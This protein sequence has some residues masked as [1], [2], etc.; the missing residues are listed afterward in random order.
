MQLVSLY[1]RSGVDIIREIKFRD[2]INIIT[3]S[4]DDG[5][6]IGKSTTLRAIKFCL[7]SDGTNLWHDPDSGVTNHEIFDL[8]VSGIVSF[9]LNLN[10]NGKPIKIV[11][12]MH[13]KTS[14]I[15]RVSWINGTKYSFHKK[16]KDEISNI[17]GHSPSK[18]SFS[19]IQNRFF[20]LD[21]KSV[22]ALYRYNNAFTSNDDYRLI[23]SHLFG[24]SGHAELEKDLDFKAE[25]SS[26]E[27]R[28]SSLLNGHTE[29]EYQDKLSSIGD[30][31][32]TLTE[33][34]EL[35]DI[36]GV[37]NN[38]IKNVRSCREEIAYISS[39]ITDLETR[40]LYNEKTIFD[41]EAKITRIDS[42]V[43]ASIYTEAKTIIPDLST[44]F[45]DAINFHNSMF[46][47]KAVYVASQV[48]VLRGNL[49]RHKIRLN[50]VLDTEKNLFK[51]IVNESHL[52]GFILIEREIQDKREERGKI[53]YVV[54][55][56]NSI[57]LDISALSD[58][59]L[60]MQAL[61]RRYVSDFRDN[62]LA[63]NTSCK[64]ITKKVFNDFSIYFNTPEDQDNSVNFT[65]IN[66]DK[67]LGDGSPR[68]A[69][70]AVDMAFVEYAKTTG[71][72]MPLFT[73]QD[74]LEA[75]DEDKLS[76]LFYL[77]DKRKIQTVVSILNDKLKSLD[78]EFRKE[79]TVLTL[80][81]HDKFFKI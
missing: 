29:I 45:E 78:S 75:S 61:V 7:G 24:F 4:G 80:S 57:N 26:L 41:Y 73:L 20:R 27:V 40:I 42:S 76:S 25:I 68:A 71:A 52:G 15:S 16:F 74:Y 1:V 43:V 13:K 65:V 60:A 23:Y 11:R 34:E 3:N 22:N 14:Q 51:N 50:V 70:M 79:S 33:K 10:I 5:N 28:R 53:S 59:R 72:K 58:D 17:F 2:G 44:T 9:E 62:L 67:V 64:S 56:V 66:N 30:D 18:P 77:A 6:Q 8:L 35:Y 81:S 54:D 21:K 69:S 37:Q 63:F 32:Q 55:E 12:T 31:L 39:K 19:T 38:A 48:K 46:E 49:E 47:K 36:K